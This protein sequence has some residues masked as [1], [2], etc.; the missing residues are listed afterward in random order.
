[1]DPNL[2]KRLG[3]LTCQA[4]LD[5]DA[6]GGVSGGGDDGEP[7]N[8]ASEDDEGG[9]PDGDPDDGDDDGD[10]DDPE[11]GDDGEDEAEDAKLGE[12]ARKR[13]GKLVK[14]RNA[15]NAE[16]ARLKEEL[17]GA[18]KL[19]GDDG[20][21]ILAAA[22]R[23]GI[24]PG[25]MT[26]DEAQAFDAL[27]QYPRVI[28]RYQDWLDEHGPDDEFGDGDDAM[29]YGAVKKRVRRLSAELEDLKDGYGARQKELQ[30]KVRQIF[31]LGMKAYRKG[32]KAGGEG[33]KPEDKGRKAKPKQA[34]R[35]RGT[36]PVAKGGRKS[37]WG[38]V[39]GDDSFVR[40]IASENEGEE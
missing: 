23:S 14:E 31:D 28:E 20:K 26:K 37:N 10:D 32:A 39:D 33:G 16:L 11:D 34:V 25:L 4:A 18:R 24:L 7:G 8:G 36:K 12:R 19:A 3:L 29:S 5:D 27:A 1:M 15:A 40:M 30:Q 9:E 13:I 21:A 2:L 38:A 6:G 17:D 22:R 35:P